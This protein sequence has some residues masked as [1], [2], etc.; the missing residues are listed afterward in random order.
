MAEW[1]Q[2]VRPPPLRPQMAIFLTSRQTGPPTKCP[3]RSTTT[4][5]RPTGTGG[6]L[7]SSPSRS[8][9]SGSNCGFFTANHSKSTDGPLP[10][11]NRLLDPSQILATQTSSLARSYPSKT[12]LPPN[13]ANEPTTYVADYLTAIRKHTMETLNRRYGRSKQLPPLP[14]PPLPRPC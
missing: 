4:A 9:I 14:S 11:P 13:Y 12:E 1:G 3:P 8:G 7:T 10:P 6:V 5:Q 2:Q